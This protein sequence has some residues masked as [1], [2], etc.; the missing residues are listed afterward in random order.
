MEGRGLGGLAE[1]G[2]DFW[3]EGAG[4]IELFFGDELPILFL[5]VFDASFDPPVAE[6]ALF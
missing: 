2:I 5:D 1:D 3:E 6:A 4:I